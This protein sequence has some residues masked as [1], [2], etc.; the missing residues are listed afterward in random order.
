MLMRAIQYQW[1]GAQ[2]VVR[3]DAVERWDGPM[4]QPSDAEI[5]AALA[6]YSA[7]Q[8]TIDMDGESRLAAAQRA[9]AALAWVLLRRLAP[10][11]TLAQTKAKHA[12]L[13]DDVAAAYKAQ[14]WL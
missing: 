3:G 5:A 9:I 4:P 7:A 1:P 11:D 2:C 10:A 8:P 14:P 13:R 12:V 6:A